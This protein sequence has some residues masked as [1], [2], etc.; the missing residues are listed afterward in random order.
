MTIFIT[1]EGCE[2]T[3]RLLSYVVPP[4]VRKKKGISMVCPDCNGKG[5]KEV[6]NE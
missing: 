2:G 1:C 3:G 5:C 4:N 6:E